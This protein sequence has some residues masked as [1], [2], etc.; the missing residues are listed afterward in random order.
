M[1]PTALTALV[2]TGIAI[3]TIVVYIIT[4]IVVYAVAETL[5]GEKTAGKIIRIWAFPLVAIHWY[6]SPR[7]FM[8]WLFDPLPW[9]RFTHGPFRSSPEGEWQRKRREEIRRRYGKG[10]PTTP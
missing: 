7:G 6:F 8:L 2:W 5:F 1:G 10:G 3:A 4:I 9:F